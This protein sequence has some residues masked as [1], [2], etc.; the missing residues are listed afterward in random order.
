MLEK[1]EFAMKHVE[2][3]VQNQIYLTRSNLNETELK[4]LL[5]IKEDVGI[6]LKTMQG[7]NF[8]QGGIWMS[9]LLELDNCVGRLQESFDHMEDAKILDLL[10]STIEPTRQDYIGSILGLNQ[11]AIDFLSND[12]DNYLTEEQ[13]IL[14]FLEMK[15][16]SLYDQEYDSWEEAFKILGFTPLKAKLLGQLADVNPYSSH[17]SPAQWASRHIEQLFKSNILLTCTN[18]NESQYQWNTTHAI[19]VP[20]EIPTVAKNPVYISAIDKFVLSKDELLQDPH[21]SMYLKQPTRPLKDVSYWYHG[22][23]W[24]SAL[25]IIRT[26]IDVTKGRKQLDFSD[27]SGFYLTR[28][29]RQN[30]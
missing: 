22:T 26:G 10:N 17:D 23:D 5:G 29:L 4:K 9:Q 12:C 2:D 11:E 8:H 20:Y 19:D 25:N 30:H 14:E 18:P 7:I 1:L 27:G 24:S 13:W 16:I 28:Y 6:L 21:F 3:D 15:E